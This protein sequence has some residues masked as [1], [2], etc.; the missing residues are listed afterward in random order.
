MKSVYLLALCRTPIGSFGGSLKGF[1]A[2]ELG[3]VVVKAALQRC[4]VAAELVDEVILGNVLQ[5]AQGQNPARQAALLAGIPQEVPAVTINKVCGSGLYTVALARQAILSGEAECVVAGGME[6]MSN[7]PFALENQRWGAKLG[8]VTARDILVYDGLWDVFN[9]Y[10]M[11]ITAENVA[12]MYG[13]TRAQQDE[14]AVD[15][16]RK[17]AAAS[18]SGRFD[19]EIVPLEVKQGKGKSFIFDRDEY[20]KAETTLE[21][22]SGL[23]PAFKPDGTVTAANASGINDG[24]A[25]IIVASAEFV[26]RHKLTPLAEIV[27]TGSAGVDPALMGTGPIPAV[28][29]ALPKAGLNVDDLDLIEANEAFAAQA[30][31]V[32]QEL[33]LDPAKLNV[34]GGAIALGHPIGASGARILTS[35]VYEM[36]R[37]NSQYGAATLCIG[38]GMGE[39][40]IVKLC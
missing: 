29:K 27:A 19:D 12:E 2:A 4:G 35:L 9:Q 24:A 25:A 3:A 20:I 34:N 21:K 22:I 39:A 18:F 31:V 36:K 8:D 38:G 23:R 1:K 15:S 14:F 40:M 30:I 17:A 7:C 11:G 26:D 6:S 33:G 13:I 32:A 28:K 5:A 37:R 16:Q 10:H